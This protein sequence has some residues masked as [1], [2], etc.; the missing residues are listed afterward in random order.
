MVSQ[1]RNGLHRAYALGNPVFI[2]AIVYAPF[3]VLKY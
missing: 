3:V 1:V 2:I